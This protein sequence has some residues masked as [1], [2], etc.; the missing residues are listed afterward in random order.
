MTS[1]VRLEL[2]HSAIRAF[3][4]SNDVLEELAARAERIA[5]AAAQN[6]GAINPDPPTYAVNKDIGRQRARVSV[7]TTNDAARAGE[8]VHHWLLGA[9]D[10]GR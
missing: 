6:R 9:L 7:A 2:N 3:L 8:A 5:G 10:A 1:P 4:R